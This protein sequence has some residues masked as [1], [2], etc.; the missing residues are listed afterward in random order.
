MSVEKLT[1]KQGETSVKIPVTEK[2]L[3]FR[4]GNGDLE[5]HASGMSATKIEVGDSINI[6]QF[7]NIQV[8]NLFAGDNTVELQ[9]TD[10]EINTGGKQLVEIVG[11]SLDSVNTPLSVNVD[12]SIKDGTVSIISPSSLATAIDVPCPANQRTK[13][14]GSGERNKVLIQTVGTNATTLRVGDT[15]VALDRGAVLSGSLASVGSIELNT[16]GDV[17]VFNT[18]ADTKV[19]VLEVKQ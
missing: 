19:S 13:I 15:N 7:P 9:N 1:L 8:K 17:Y 6:E 10:L 2:F 11:G 14:I 18:G 4:S 5:L 12:N 16:K 3:I